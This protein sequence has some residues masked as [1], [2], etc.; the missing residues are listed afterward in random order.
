[1]SHKLENEEL[2]IQDSFF[3]KKIPNRNQEQSD[4]GFS[5]DNSSLKGI[6]PHK[7]VRLLGSAGTVYFSPVILVLS[8]F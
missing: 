4:F 1:M 6:K 8:V 2:N 5:I 3:A 7:S